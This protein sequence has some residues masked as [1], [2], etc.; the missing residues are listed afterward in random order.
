MGE[1]GD[2]CMV[3]R[4]PVVTTLCMQVP[5]SPNVKRFKILIKLSI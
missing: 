4:I 5:Y 3:M 1:K 2:L